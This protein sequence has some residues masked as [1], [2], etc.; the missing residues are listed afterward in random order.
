[1]NGSSCVDN[2]AC[3]INNICNNGVCEGKT[4]TCAVENQCRTGF[5]QNGV[6]CVYKNK[7]NGFSCNIYQLN[8]TTAL[9]Y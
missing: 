9:L 8:T 2:N 3:T 6:G 4:L 7:P 1:M 5:C